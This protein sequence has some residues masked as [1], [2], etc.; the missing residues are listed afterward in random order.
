MA[1][2]VRNFGEHSLSFALACSGGFV[3]C[4]PQALGPDG[5]H[6]LLSTE[7]WQSWERVQGWRDWE[8]GK[9]LPAGLGH[10]Q[11]RGVSS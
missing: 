9:A 3:L 10:M 1:E 4:L 2:A 5:D 7:P 8:G 6:V 11:G